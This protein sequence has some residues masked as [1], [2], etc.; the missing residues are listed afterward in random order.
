ME[1]DRIFRELKARVP[2]EV[3]LIGVVGNQGAGKTHF[4]RELSNYLVGQGVSSVGWNCDMYT[5]NSRPKKR[6]LV[7]QLRGIDPDWA[8]KVFMN[9]RKDLALEHF[10]KLKTEVN[11]SARGLYNQGTGDLDLDLKVN[12]DKSGVRIYQGVNQGIYERPVWI[13]LDSDFI[14]EASLRG[15]LDVVFFMQASMEKRMQRV[16]ERC[17]NLAKPFELDEQLFLET[18]Q[19]LE[20]YFKRNVTPS[21]TDIIIDN[22]DFNNRRIIIP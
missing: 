5:V 9:Y 20:D 21:A 11:F 18:N 1:F 10:T 14:A 2:G 3:G 16:K 12:F 6:E 17:R 19:W 13:L 4:N 22:E 8:E 15:Q 7:K